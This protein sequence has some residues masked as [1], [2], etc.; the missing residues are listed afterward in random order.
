[1]IE[2]F[3]R[4]IRPPDEELLRMMA[5]IGIQVGQ[6]IE[7]KQAEEALA[8]ERNVLRSLIGNL[9]DH[10]YVKDSQDGLAIRDGVDDPTRNV[11]V[12]KLR[13]WERKL[14]MYNEKNLSRLEVC[15]QIF[16]S[17]I[18]RVLAY[19]YPVHVGL[20]TF[21]TTSKLAQ[22][23]SAIVENFRRAI[24]KMEAT[25]DTALWDALAL[26]C[27]ELR[28]SSRKY[29]DAKKRIICL[30]DGVDNKS[31]KSVHDVINLVKKEDI[32]V[33]SF[34]IGNDNNS[35]LRVVSYLTGGYKF[36][37]KTLDQAMAMCEMEPVLCQLERPTIVK[38]ANPNRVAFARL[39]GNAATAPETVNRDVFPSRKQHPG[40]ADQFVQLSAMAKVHRSRSTDTESTNAIPANRF[41]RMN[42]RVPRLLTEIKNI[43]TNI[44]PYYDVYV[45]ESNIGFWKVVLQGVR[46]DPILPPAV[47]V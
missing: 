32:V 22:A 40:L 21:E 37:P 10:F 20:V 1:M 7:R 2:F 39:K 41:S 42:T 47:E 43:A 25:G 11:L 29:P 45:S 15:K 16:G 14:T 31:E 18:N 8:E 12:L 13:L 33:D 24:D 28:E 46:L 9:P 34:C 17:F 4:E 38:H 30:S 5:T 44:H 6:F 27:D 3:S 19:N 36:A 26:A 35:E 23:P